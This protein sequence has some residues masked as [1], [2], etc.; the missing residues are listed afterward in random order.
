MCGIFG[1]MWPDSAAV[2]DQGRLQQTLD[3]LHHRG[4]D[5]RGTFAAPG[6]ALA[7][8]R[9]SLLDLDDRSNQPFWDAQR[10]F[11]L[12]YNGEIYNHVP[13]RAALEREGRRFRT[14]C[15]TEV[16]L[17]AILA[18]GADA[19]L[20][21]FDGMFALGLY[22][23]Q[24][25]SLLLARDRFGT[26]P[27]FIYES[28]DTMVF[29]SSIAAMRP[30]VALEP[31]PFSISSYLYGFSGPTKGA[32]FFRHI[33]IVEPAGVVRIEHASPARRTQFF[34]F[35]Q[36]VNRHEIERLA[37]LNPSTTVDRVDEL[38]NESV[39]L[40]LVSDAPVGTLCSGGLD[41]SIIT[42][43]A[44]RY[45]NNLAVFH[46]DVV[47]PVSERDAATQ[48]ARH[49]KLDLHAAE[50]RD[51][52]F[53]ELIPEVTEHFGH[54]F[55][56]CPHSVPYLTICRLVRQTGVK[57]VLS[58]EAS[59]ELFL[60]YADNALP[61]GTTARSRMMQ[62]LRRLAG[63]PDTDARMRY[64]G[65]SYVQGGDAL[66]SA[67]LIHGLHNR[68]E[69]VQETVD[70]RNRIGEDSSHPRFRGVLPSLDLL[71]YNLRAL[72]HRNDAMGMASSVEARFPFLDHE[73]VQLGVNMPYDRKRRRELRTGRAA[74][75]F[76]VNKWVLRKV[77]ERYVPREIFQRPKRPFPINAYAGERMR[78][79]PAYFHQSL[80][81]DLFGLDSAR[82]AM[83]LNGSSHWLKWRMLLLD[84]W[85]QVCLDGS[86][87]AR[88]LD[89]L[90][91][92]VTIV[93]PQFAG[94]L[95]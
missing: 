15:D 67:G 46:A 84:V 11:A 76:S 20:P 60:G 81:V 88:A 74:E 29:A 82:K 95:S 32:S 41:S 26:K 8:T 23:A 63:R 42:A 19:A 80:I 92:H 33:S 5:A 35:D 37:T 44:S 93:N 53:I 62:R 25:R 10:R 54:P 16:V 90:H 69:T 28:R 48:I 64:Q 18:W 3:L 51:A 89:K 50:V 14:T 47:G 52:D 55:Y 34:R 85:G 12:V 43:I 30:W 72:L 66:T 58:G 49:L 21:R 86:S 38:L 17:E 59:D 24:E 56:S 7:H 83:F 68:F 4:P 71:G 87:R 6:L 65:P 70:I 1:V 94:Y 22:D 31:D 91:R 79:D 27:L 13:L 2:P 36:F 77:A 75:A 45:S 40:Q 73:L 39:K 57:A 78:I 61:D 9:L